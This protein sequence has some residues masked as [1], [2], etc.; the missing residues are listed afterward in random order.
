MRNRMWGY[1]D[2]GGGKCDKKQKFCNFSSHFYRFL[3]IHFCPR[4][5]FL[6]AHI[7]IIIS[8]HNLVWLN[9]F[10]SC[11]CC[12]CASDVIFLYFAR[13]CWHSC[14]YIHIE[15]NRNVEWVVFIHCYIFLCQCWFLFLCS[16]RLGFVTNSLWSS[17]GRESD[18]NICI[19]CA[20]VFAQLMHVFAHKYL[21]ICTIKY[22][23]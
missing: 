22:N 16:T 4:T 8:V 5:L 6:F 3:Y 7:S 9:F 11:D 23:L 12:C 10:S 17:F 20:H 2:G 21:N 19:V 14:I 15:C 13:F 1:G 18:C